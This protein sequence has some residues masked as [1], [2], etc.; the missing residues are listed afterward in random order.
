MADTDLLTQAVR[1]NALWCDTVCRA[2]GSPGLFEAGLWWNPRPAPRFYPNLVTL[3]AGGAPL[4]RLGAV[5]AQVG[6]GPGWGLKDSYA[7]LDLAGLGFRPL[8]D[9]AW[10]GLPAG[11]RQPGAG[12]ADLEWRRVARPDELA[13]WEAAWDGVPEVAPQ[14][15][16]F[17]PALL[18]DP[19]VALLAAVRDGRIVGGAVANRTGAVVGV[20]NVFARGDAGE[21]WWAEVAAAAR[22]VFPGLALVGYERGDDLDQALG[23]GFREIGQLRVWLRAEGQR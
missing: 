2:H 4:P 19:E 23:A 7:A 5:C 9:A 20:S 10:I 15:R 1:N 16:V 3:A 21:G 22:R 18:D 17:P 11:Q 8:F 12:A 14:E 6:A 13:A